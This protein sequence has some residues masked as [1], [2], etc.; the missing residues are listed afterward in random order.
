[1]RSYLAQRKTMAAQLAIDRVLRIYIPSEL[2]F[3]Q[4]SVAVV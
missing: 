1:M 4:S 2:C 3:I